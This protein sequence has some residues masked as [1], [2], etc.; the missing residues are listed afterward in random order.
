MENT[1]QRKNNILYSKV[2]GKIRVILK[3]ISIMEEKLLSV[4]KHVQRH[5]YFLA[6]KLSKF[7]G[8][9]EEHELVLG[10]LACTLL[11]FLTS[12]RDLTSS[13]SS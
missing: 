6:T 10:Y 4:S 8:Q 9:G 3:H 12:L 2:V 11:L 13:L 1:H 5:S 7:Q